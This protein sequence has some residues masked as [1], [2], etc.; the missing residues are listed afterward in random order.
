[1]NDKQPTL[2]IIFPVY[3]EA[4][5]LNTL[6]DSIKDIVFKIEMPYELLFVDDGSRDSSLEI[7]QNLSERDDCV[8]YISLSRNFGHQMAIL[9]GLT[10]SQG[11]VVI[12]MDADL[13]HPPELIPEMVSLWR[14]GYEVVYTLKRNYPI[15]FYKLIQIRLFY[16]CISRISG[17]NLSFGQ[18]D[19]RLLD[20][21]VVDVILNIPEYRKFLRGLV[22]WAG[23]RQIG[24]AY[25]VNKRLSGH[26][27]FSYR[28][29]I[30]FAL[31]GILSFSNVPLRLMTIIGLI[32]SFF[33]F[34]YALWVILS[35]YIKSLNP[36]VESPSGWTSLAVLL[37]F[38][39]GMQ[40]ITTG[41]L[42]EYISRIY[43]QI[44]GRPYY[45]VRTQSHH[46]SNR[47]ELERLQKKEDRDDKLG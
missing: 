46:I 8:R 20:R 47:G 18:S 10:Y 13:Q 41:V 3:N 26:S 6:Y 35:K 32:I 31:D 21:Q 44:K 15:P 28:S 25:D 2:S 7:I 27:K 11:E 22:D 9:A 43:E 34:L 40:L 1:M 37:T 19:F 17:L 16:W 12:T 36:N 14:Q 33:S 29:Q 23:F 4:E 5:N 45:I 42:G 38:F 24:L 30:D 39:G